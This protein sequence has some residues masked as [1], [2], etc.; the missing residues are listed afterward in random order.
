MATDVASTG[1]LLPG[2]D[3][4]WVERARTAYLKVESNLNSTVPVARPTSIPVPD[5]VCGALVF[6]TTSEPPPGGI[7]NRIEDGTVSCPALDGAW[8]KNLTD[9][10]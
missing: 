8:Q 7:A 10:Y 6:I 9:P 3:L 1:K 4:Q 5:T 2:Q